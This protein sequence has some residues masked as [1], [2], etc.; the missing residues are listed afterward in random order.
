MITHVGTTSVF[1]KD[2]DAA[3]AFY[4][5]KL[6]FEKIAD[7]PMGP[8]SRWIEVAPPGGETAV[9]LYKPTP[10]QPGASSYEVALATIGKFQTILFRCDDVEATCKELTAKGVKFPTPAKEEPW[11]WWAVFEDQD[12]NSFGIAQGG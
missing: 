12:G 4:V 6:G 8:G 9:L 1:V 10:E 2:Q 3:L 11:G 7:E 5:D